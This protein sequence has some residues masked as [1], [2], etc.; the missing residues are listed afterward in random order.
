MTVE[1]SCLAL[2]ENAGL[3]IPKWNKATQNKDQGSSAK[4]I[5]LI[6]RARAIDENVAKS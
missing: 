4:R 3:S 6:T 1:S 5:A 2:L